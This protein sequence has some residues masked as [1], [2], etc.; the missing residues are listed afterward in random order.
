MITTINEMIVIM[1]LEPAVPRI[2]FINLKYFKRNRN[3]I[4]NLLILKLIKPSK[5]LANHKFE[6]IT[7]EFEPFSI[8]QSKIS[9]PSQSVQTLVVF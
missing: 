8:N 7:I 2:F 9:G 1:S 6:I 5:L 3:F 4:Y